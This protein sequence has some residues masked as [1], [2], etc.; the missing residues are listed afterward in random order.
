MRNS[1]FDTLT[2]TKR[3]STNK[4][5]TFTVRIVQ[6]VEEMGGGRGE[7][8]LD[9]LLKCIDLFSRRVFSNLRIGK[10]IHNINL[11]S[12]PTIFLSAPNC[13]I[14]QSTGA[15]DNEIS[16]FQRKGRGLR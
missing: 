9:V 8:V 13:K 2:E 5:R 4:V 3:V 16:P 15:T 7:E 12:G 1:S 11:V 6:G 10:K 14:H